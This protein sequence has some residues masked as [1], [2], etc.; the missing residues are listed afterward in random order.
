MKKYT[1]I[2][3]ILILSIS[4]VA[5][6]VGIT[7]DNNNINNIAAG[8][9]N[10]EFASL[11]AEPSQIYLLET[12]GPIEPLYKYNVLIGSYM[13]VCEDSLCNHE[14]D[15]GCKFANIGMTVTA[16][17]WVYF[18]KTENRSSAMRYLI[19]GYN[20]LTSEFKVLHTN[21]VNGPTG[22]S[23][24]YNEGYIYFFLIP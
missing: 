16:G 24:Q 22:I 20:Y 10:I 23:I 4:M 14:R 21:D 17:D 11:S 19:C 6:G 13:P 5:C 18:T 1:F 3:L 7:A 2:T 8:I 9:P 15:S 12:S